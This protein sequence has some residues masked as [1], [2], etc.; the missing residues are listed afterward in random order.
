MTVTVKD[1]YARYDESA[2]YQVATD[3]VYRVITSGLLEMHKWYTIKTSGIGTNFVIVGAADNNV[4]TTFQA[5]TDTVSPTWTN[6]S[7]QVGKPIDTY[8]TEYINNARVDLAGQA[9]KAGGTVDETNTYQIEFLICQTMALLCDNAGLTDR[10][11]RLKS[12][13][14]NALYAIWGSIVYEGNDIATETK[15]PPVRPMSAAITKCD[16]TE[17]NDEMNWD[18]V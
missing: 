10:S 9:L 2:I 7:L 15:L 4:G 1:I 12:D 11:T 13:A 17:I 5:L 18:M 6:G 3:S 16:F 14:L 8:I